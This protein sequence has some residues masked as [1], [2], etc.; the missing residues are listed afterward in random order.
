MEDSA[1][2]D[3]GSEESLADTD[4]FTVQIKN[5]NRSYENLQHGI[6]GG[7]MH[8]RRSVSRIMHVDKS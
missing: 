6:S 8:F 5:L 7:D 2:C 1:K 3:Y 4:T